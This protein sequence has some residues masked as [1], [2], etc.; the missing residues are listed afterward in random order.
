MDVE[1][2]LYTLGL[3]WRAKYLKQLADEL[4]LIKIPLDYENLIKLPAI[5]DYVA[6]AFLSLHGHKR[7]ILIDTNVVRFVC[8]FIGQTSDGET[9]REKWFIRFIDDLTPRNRWKDFNYA[10]LDFSMIICKQ[11]PLCVICP[12]NAMCKYFTKGAL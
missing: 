7:A 3:R 1:K 5:G 6:S 2:L 8:R 10:I 4:R 11:R 9:R 12:I